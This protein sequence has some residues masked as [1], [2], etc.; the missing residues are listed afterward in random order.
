MNCKAGDLAR[1]VF[2][3][4]GHE[5]K[6]VRCLWIAEDS[7]LINPD[8]TVTKGPVWETDT[9]LYREGGLHSLMLDCDLRPIRN[10]GDDETDESHAWL[11]PV[12]TPAE[13]TA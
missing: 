7:G 11:P 12:P 3:H 4:H 5:G 2:S 13:A 6:I 10:P 8:F 9:P 1:I